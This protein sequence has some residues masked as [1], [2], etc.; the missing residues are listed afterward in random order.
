MQKTKYQQL[1]NVKKGSVTEGGS[2]TGGGGT[3]KVTQLWART[4]A[5]SVFRGKLAVTT[6]T[7][8]AT[9]VATTSCSIASKPKTA[10]RGHPQKQKQHGSNNRKQQKESS[11][12]NKHCDKDLSDGGCNHLLTWKGSKKRKKQQKHDTCHST[13]S[14]NDSDGGCNH[15]L[16]KNKKKKKQQQQQQQQCDN[17]DSDSSNDGGCSH[18]LT[19]RET[20]SKRKKK[21]VKQSKTSVWDSD[22]EDSGGYNLLLSMCCSKT[23]V[24]K[25]MQWLWYLQQSKSMGSGAGAAGTGSFLKEYCSSSSWDG[26][27]EEEE[28]LCGVKSPHRDEDWSSEDSWEEEGVAPTAPTGVILTPTYNSEDHMKQIGERLAKHWGKFILVD[29]NK[30]AR[31][32]MQCFNKM[33]AWIVVETV[34]I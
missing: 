4:T 12:N 13:D 15:L 30:K 22:I 7:S 32:V 2:G 28:L 16:N 18:L 5:C 19:K 9:S 14:D 3:G 6:V 20:S 24:Q 27:E 10:V 17:T 21:E 29:I 34:K 23:M 1:Q 31:G 26:S 8:V 25:S 11:C 33:V